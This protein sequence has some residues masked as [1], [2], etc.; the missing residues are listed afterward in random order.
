MAPPRLSGTTLGGL[1]V[2][3]LIGAPP[4]HEAKMRLK[5]GQAAV[6][7]TAQTVDGETIS[8]A[9]FAG[10]PLLL[11]FL[12]YA[13]CPMC[14]LQLHD[15]ARQYPRLRDR[16]LEAV[17]FFH[18][19]APSI[20]AHAGGHHYPFALVADPE[21][22]IYGPYGVETSWSR[23]LLSMARPSFYVAWLRSLR[24]GLWGG[25]AWQMA[26]MPADFLIGPDGRIVMAHYGQDIGDHLPIAS[27]T[28]LLA[29]LERHAAAES[30]TSIGATPPLYPEV[31]MRSL[32]T[33]V[34][35]SLLW[36]LALVGSSFFL[37]GF[38]IGDWVDALLY[39][40]AGVWASTFW[41]RR[42]VSRCT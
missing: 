6:S 12:R 10:K 11:M 7:F 28:T 38:A 18:S 5:S 14:N 13:S 29:E 17:A 32:S 31:S 16:G 25:V 36:A 4:P 35:L 19:A 24:H 27:I 41:L 30:P 1:S 26:K 2:H 39:L 42:P 33:V 8:L 22:R 20:R 23:L 34:A 37:K 40:S 15:F 3:V 21:F 9:Q